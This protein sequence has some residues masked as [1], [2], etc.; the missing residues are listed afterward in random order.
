MEAALL[1]ALSPRAASAAGATL[2]DSPRAASPSIN[3]AVLSPPFADAGAGEAGSGLGGSAAAS[4]SHSQRQGGQRPGQPINQ[5][6]ERRA[7]AI[8]MHAEAL[9]V[10]ESIL[11]ATAK[12]PQVHRA[13]GVDGFLRASPR[14]DAPSRQAGSPG[15]GSALYREGASG[16]KRAGAPGVPHADTGRPGHPRDAGEAEGHSNGANASRPPSDDG[17]LPRQSPPQLLASPAADRLPQP[18][19]AFTSPEEVLEALEDA[20]ARTDR[21]IALHGVG[22]PRL[23]ASASDGSNYGAGIDSPA[24]AAV[25]STRTGGSVVPALPLHGPGAQHPTTHLGRSGTRMGHRSRASRDSADGHV[26]AAERELA[27]GLQSVRAALAALGLHP[28]D[29]AAA[30]AV[31]SPAS[32]VAAMEAAVREST[33]ASARL[34]GLHSG[35]A[36]P[37]PSGSGSLGSAG[38]ERATDRGIAMAH[39]EAGQ[40]LAALLAHLPP[41]QSRQ[42]RESIA[43]AASST[44]GRAPGAGGPR[45]PSAPAV[46]WE[47]EEAEDERHSGDA[48]SLIE[49]APPIEALLAGAGYGTDIRIVNPLREGARSSGGGPAVAGR[50]GRG[51]AA[52]GDGSHSSS[53]P[54]S[55]A[56]G[57]LTSGLWGPGEAGLSQDL[58][59]ALRRA[60]RRARDAAEADAS[61]EDAGVNEVTGRYR[62]VVPRTPPPPPPERHRYHGDVDSPDPLQLTAAA[63]AGGDNDEESSVGGSLAEWERAHTRRDPQPV[64]RAQLRPQHG[65]QALATGPLAGASHQP[66]GSAPQPADVHTKALAV[67]LARSAA[68]A[69]A[70]AGYSEEAAVDLMGHGFAGAGAA[71]ALSA[72]AH[73]RINAAADSAL[74]MPLP[75]LDPILVQFA[76]LPW[77]Y[78]VNAI[79]AARQAAEEAAA[80]SDS[81][82]EETHH[83]GGSAARPLALVDA[84]GTRGAGASPGVRFQP[85][86]GAADARSHSPQSAAQASIAAAARAARRSRRATAAALAAATATAAAAGLGAG[87]LQR[88][89]DRES[90]FVRDHVYIPPLP[91]SY[92]GYGGKGPLQDVG[93]AAQQATETSHGSGA[94]FADDRTRAP[95]AEASAGGQGSSESL[96]RS[97]PRAVAGAPAARARLLTTQA[98]LARIAAEQAANGVNLH[99]AVSGTDVAWRAESTGAEAGADLYD[100]RRQHTQYHREWRAAPDAGTH[101]GAY[102]DADGTGSDDDAPTA[103]VEEPEGVLEPGPDAGAPLSWQNGGGYPEDT[104]HRPA[105]ESPHPGGHVDESPRPES[106]RTGRS[107][108]ERAQAAQLAAAAAEA[109]SGPVPWPSLPDVLQEAGDTVARMRAAGVLHERTHDGSLHPPSHARYGTDVT[110]HHSTGAAPAGASH[111]ATT[112]D[113]A[114]SGGLEGLPGSPPSPASIGSDHVRALLERHVRQME[115]RQAAKAAERAAEAGRQHAMLAALQRERAQHQ[116]AVMAAMGLD[117]SRLQPP[118]HRGHQ[119]YRTTASAAGGGSAAG[120]TAGTQHSHTLPAA[121]IDPS[122]VLE[123]QLRYLQEQPSD[124]SQAAWSPA[125][126][127]APDSSGSSGAAAVPLPRW[128]PTPAHTAAIS[129]RRGEPFTQ[130]KTPASPRTPAGYDGFPTGLRHEVAG[131]AG[132]GGFRGAAADTSAALDAGYRALGPA[133][134]IGSTAGSPFQRSGTT[135]AAALRYATVPLTTRYRIDPATGHGRIVAQPQSPLH[136]AEAAASLLAYTSATGLA[137]GAASVSHVVDGTLQQTRPANG[138]S[139]SSAFVQDGFGGGFANGALDLFASTASLHRTG[140]SHAGSP[141]GAASSHAAVMEHS[142]EVKAALSSLQRLLS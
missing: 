129:P 109:A 125:N 86:A 137:D 88:W 141:A 41:S 61:A 92:A 77:P 91:A 121:G 38:A 124:G 119:D 9:A 62:G 7:G 33:G 103:H 116:V 42:V 123:L 13:A 10:Y 22:Q 135:T 112:A 25:A 79:I 40:A 20:V 106:A 57:H 138:V 111:L 102:V 72:E 84:A 66:L 100:G 97:L 3:A 60:L 126:A 55:S 12:P 32:A 128:G 43:V 45:M 85:D 132:S 47:E 99:G 37:Q 24:A 71:L 120:H 18:K 131:A 39:V 46:E 133:S 1:V 15:G 142:P 35:G 19:R 2:M 29:P 107:R 63:G 11:S 4:N 68:A 8:T 73:A 90:R 75:E 139:P 118:L 76:A 83:S 44:A 64:Q 113:G 54:A 51:G 48:G 30:A 27:Q 81:D 17:S 95:R 117:V 34:L 21:Q 5:S 6:G 31:G 49:D 115:E 105:A 89:R 136:P 78:N 114:R 69:A 28:N 59:S 58:A 80:Q 26:A 94:S 36:S 122:A 67:A 93:A 56:S 134:P 50:S 108:W 140:P 96:Q 130:V 104:L 98:T 65:Q 127:L 23:H 74:R 53:S 14:G 70:A 52:T 16:R 101:E 87:G 110:L 82:E